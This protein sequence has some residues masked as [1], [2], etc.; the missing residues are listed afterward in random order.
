MF[1]VVYILN[2]VTAIDTI[3]IED[4]REENNATRTK[5]INVQNSTEPAPTVIIPV[6]EENADDDD[7]SKEGDGDN[8]HQKQQQPFSYNN[9]RRN[10]THLYLMGNNNVASA[11]HHFRH[12]TPNRTN[13]NHNNNNGPASSS[14][15][16]HANP[17]PLDDSISKTSNDH[18]RYSIN[19]LFP[20]GRSL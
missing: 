11:I 15:L 3:R 9:Q 8:N 6:K 7:E 16:S 19:A 1:C 10:T 20:R 4:D 18:I 2:N 14:P 13:H 17:K 12:Q 5:S